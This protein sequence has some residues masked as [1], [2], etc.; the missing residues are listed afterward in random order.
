MKL[1]VIAACAL[2]LAGCVSVEEDGESCEGYGFKSGSD[3]YAACMMELDTR[4][5]DKRAAFGAALQ[6]AGN[7]YSAAM[8]PPRPV[9]CTYT[10]YGNSVRQACY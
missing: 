3:A 8:R 9:N 6:T 5:S 2:G 10:G 1:L 4:R 7:N